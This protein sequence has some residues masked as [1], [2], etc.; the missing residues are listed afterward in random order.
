MIGLKPPRLIGHLV[1]IQLEAWC[2]DVEALRITEGE[3]TRSLTSVEAGHVG[4]LR[5]VSRL[6]L[7]LSGNE[8]VAPLPAGVRGEGAGG[9]G[10]AA[11]EDETVLAGRAARKV[12]MGNVLDQADDSEI[13]LLPPN[14]I[15]ALVTS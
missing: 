12:K 10:R 11:V 3:A 9:G 7:G 13:A 2:A 5:R 14:S 8:V 15:S 1:A 4:V 6:V